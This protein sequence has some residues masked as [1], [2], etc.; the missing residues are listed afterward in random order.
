MASKEI[1]NIIQLN[2]G[3]DFRLLENQQIQ[4]LLLKLVVLK[5]LGGKNKLS[6]KLKQMLDAFTKT[7]TTQCLRQSVCDK[8][9]NSVQR[10]HTK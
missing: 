9:F 5:K 2:V 1:K 4:L 3:P 6:P 10:S 8:H 7:R